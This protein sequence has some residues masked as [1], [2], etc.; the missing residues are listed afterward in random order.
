MGR[1]DCE[2]EGR[3]ESS[4]SLNI[5]SDDFFRPNVLIAVDIASFS[6]VSS[7]DA[8][9]NLRVDSSSLERES[10]LVVQ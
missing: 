7:S 5:S 9:R 3:L 2:V 6:M 4:E 10:F 1:G 8:T